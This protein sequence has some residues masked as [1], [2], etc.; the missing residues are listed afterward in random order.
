[1]GYGPYGD[2][3][4]C[5]KS[6]HLSSNQ[7]KIVKQLLSIHVAHVW[8]WAIW[9]DYQIDTQAPTTLCLSAKRDARI[10]FP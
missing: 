5:L 3:P 10:P 8:M 1:M 2:F 6:P 7:N 4:P 9:I